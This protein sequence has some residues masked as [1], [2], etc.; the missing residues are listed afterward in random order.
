MVWDKGNGVP[1]PEMSADDN[2][3]DISLKEKVSEEMS[4]WKKQKKEDSMKQLLR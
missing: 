1:D 2:Q 3:V 4:L